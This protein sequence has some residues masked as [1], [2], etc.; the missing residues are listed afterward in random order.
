MDTTENSGTVPYEEVDILKE[1]L[2]LE[3]KHFSDDEEAEM[4][5]V[6]KKGGHAAKSAKETVGDPLQSRKRKRGTEDGKATTKKKAKTMGRGQA[7]FTETSAGSR[8]KKKKD[9]VSKKVVADIGASLVKM[10]GSTGPVAQRSPP[11]PPPP[12]SPL[13]PP[14]SPPSEIPHGPVS[15]AQKKVFIQSPFQSPI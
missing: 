8:G 6:L 12:Q 15:S 7:N 14:P 4:A 3:D 5:L 11:P 10:S 2:E 1:L 9:T 13:Q